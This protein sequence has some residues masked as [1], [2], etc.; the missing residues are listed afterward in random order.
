MYLVGRLVGRLYMYIHRFFPPPF[1]LKKKGSKNLSM[2]T[3]SYICTY[4]GAL[5]V[6]Q[7]NFSNR[8]LHPPSRKERKKPVRVTSYQQK[9][10][11]TLSKKKKN[12]R[13]DKP[14]AQRLLH[15]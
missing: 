14:P 7:Y 8:S 2:Q 15:M 5:C 1:F 10:E 12:S 13:F 11:K 9:K 6:E 3:D 4:V